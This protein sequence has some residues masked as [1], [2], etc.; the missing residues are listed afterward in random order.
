MGWTAEVHFSTG[1]RDTCF[2]HSVQIGPGA[3]LVGTGGS[4]PRVKVAR[5]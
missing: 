2:L 4:F 1:A 3:Y 5:A